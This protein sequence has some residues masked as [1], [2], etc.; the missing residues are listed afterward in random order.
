MTLQS[1][2]I[3]RDYTPEFVCYLSVYGTKHAFYDTTAFVPSP[4]KCRDSQFAKY[5]AGLVEGDGC[6]VVPTTV[7]DKKERL[8]YPSIQICFHLKDFPLAQLI[9]KTLGHGSLARKKGKNAYVLTVNNFE[10]IFRC[11][12]LLNG[13]MRTPKIE[14]LNAL[15]A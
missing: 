4:P 10:G 9:Q 5:F 7:R 12:F 13:N 3:L 11:I 8:I 1:V 15:I 2:G 14:E 6:I